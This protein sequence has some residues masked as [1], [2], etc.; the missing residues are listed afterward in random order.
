MDILMDILISIDIRSNTCRNLVLER[1]SDRRHFYVRE[2]V[3]QDRLVVP[4]VNAHENMADL[5]TKSLDPV[6]FHAFR[7]VIMNTPGCAH[8]ACGYVG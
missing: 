8:A 5:F 7:D 4:Y 6:K 1:S 3:E 2:L